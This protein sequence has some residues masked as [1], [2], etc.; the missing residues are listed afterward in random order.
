MYLEYSMM[1][2]G[3]FLKILSCS[4]S[5]THPL[6]CSLIGVIPFGSTSFLL[7]GYF[8]V[9]RYAMATKPLAPIFAINPILCHSQFNGID[10]GHPT[11]LF[12]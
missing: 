7:F 3:T 8:K 12:A 10:G 6:T 11:N 5:P 1:W 9:D 4:L 2:H